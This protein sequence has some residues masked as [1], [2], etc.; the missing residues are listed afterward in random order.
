MGDCEKPLCRLLDSV[1]SALR[2]T[3]T[4]D[5]GRSPEYGVEDGEG[6]RGMGSSEKE[7]DNECNDERWQMRR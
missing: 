7:K 5:S 3:E 2:E 4:G 1:V 6:W